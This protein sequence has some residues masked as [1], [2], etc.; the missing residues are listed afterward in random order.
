MNKTINLAV[1][2]LW[3]ALVALLLVTAA[4]F[5]Q[6][7]P[8]VRPTAKPA[9]KSPAGPQVEFQLS[10]D[11][12]RTK[13]V[14]LKSRFTPVV[15]GGSIVPD[16]RF[17]GCLK[18][19]SATPTGISIKDDGAIKFSGGLTIEAWVRFDEPPPDK[20]GQLAMKVG[21]FCWDVQKGKLNT[22]WLVFPSEEIVTTTPQQFKYFPV[23]GDMINGLLDVPH[24]EWTKITMSYDESLGVVTTLVDGVV[25]RRRFRY[26]GPQPMQSDGKSPIMLCSGFTNCSVAAIQCTTGRPEVIEPTMEARSE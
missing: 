15:T 18:F 10:V 4:A 8:S 3:T 20:G 6:T 25:D 2:K 17:G 24:R 7:K 13:F 23:G 9:A 12:S 1:A 19:G 14:D 26:R 16:K 21:S 5:G 22:S 11:K